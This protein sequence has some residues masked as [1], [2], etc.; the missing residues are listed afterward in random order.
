MIYTPQ[1]LIDLLDPKFT[2]NGEA[3][4][5]ENSDLA[6]RNYVL[7]LGSIEDCDDAELHSALCMVWA[8]SLQELERHVSDP[9][10]FHDWP[11]S[12]ELILTYSAA[13]SHQAIY[14]MYER[15]ILPRRMRDFFA[16]DFYYQFSDC[17]VVPVF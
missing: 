12:P 9:N 4:Y 2:D 3:G 17:P 5:I 7:S 1:E 8:D 13:V 16:N 6:G 14:E 11:V 10:V 15:D